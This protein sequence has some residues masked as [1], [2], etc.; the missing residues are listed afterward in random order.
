LSGTWLV[1][2]R[3]NNTSASTYSRLTL[4]VRTV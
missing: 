1:M 4:F 2:G 3:V